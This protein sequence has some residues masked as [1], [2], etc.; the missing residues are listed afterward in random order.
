MERV[1]YVVDQINRSNEVTKYRSENN[2]N[3][4]NVTKL[5]SDLYLIKFL[6]FSKAVFLCTILY[7]NTLFA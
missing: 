1:N 7:F 3:P 2:F 6:N 4:P 5:F